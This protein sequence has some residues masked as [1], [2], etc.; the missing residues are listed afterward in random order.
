MASPVGVPLPAGVVALMVPVTAAAL[1]AAI[2]TSIA[3]VTLPATQ[4]DPDPSGNDFIPHRTEVSVLAMTASSVGTTIDHFE[5]VVDESG[6]SCID[7]DRSSTSRMSAFLGVGANCCSPQMRVV[8]PAP[9]PPVVP[10]VPAAE[11]PAAPVPTWPQAPPHP[12]TAVVPAWPPGPEWPPWPR[13]PGV[14]VPAQPAPSNAT[15]N[16]I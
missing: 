11:L 9:P 12:A 13:P 10:K 3:L 1:P 4:A 14:L 15:D 5:A 8:P 6:G 16:E 2:P 7:A